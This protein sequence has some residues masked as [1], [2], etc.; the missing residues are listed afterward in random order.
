MLP[1]FCWL[2]GYTAIKDGGEFPV[3]SCLEC[4]GICLV[5]GVAAARR[6][7]IQYACFGCGVTYDLHELAPCDRCGNLMTSDEDSGQIC[8][9]SISDMLVD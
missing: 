1:S 6:P 3:S 5:T 8:G 7:K 4:G 9:M 2:N